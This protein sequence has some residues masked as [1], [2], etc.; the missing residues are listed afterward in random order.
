M[1]IVCLCTYKSKG[2]ALY[3]ITIR[4]LNILQEDI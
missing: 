1:Y 3:R 2:R 4:E